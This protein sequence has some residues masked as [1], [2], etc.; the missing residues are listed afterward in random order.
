VTGPEPEAGP[1]VAFGRAVVRVRRGGV[2]VRAD[3]RALVVCAAL[4]A[5]TV[6]VG[7]LGVASGDLELTLAEV[8]HAI[9]DPGAGFTRTVVVEWRIPRV[10]AALLFGA[11]LGVSGA[12]FQALTRN[13]LA[14]PDV[15]G[16]TSGAYT[17][18]LLAIIVFGGAYGTVVAG[19]L[20]GGLLTAALLYLFAYRD[21][22]QGFRLLVVGV[23]VAAMLS[24]ANT[25]LS[26]RADLGVAMSAAAWGVGSLN[27]T[28]WDHV[29][30]GGG[31]I[32]VLLAA[33]VPHA[34]AL[35]Q[36]GLGDDA[37]RASGVAVERTQ[38]VLIVLGVMLVA[39]VTAAAGPIAF[40]AL[41][42]PQ[43]GHRLARTAGVTLLPAAAMGAFLVVVADYTAQHL[44]PTTLP[45]GLVTVV[46]GGSYLVWLLVDRA[47]RR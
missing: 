43:L 47:R 1:P 21:G 29:L 19:A 16:F 32:V 46:L 5:M 36:L 26:L 11:A 39:V 7:L 8:W 28:S 25:Y 24:A 10:L 41:A 30:I 17:G 37:A 40:V 38:R 27:G 4:F 45:V 6:P 42:A 2:A 34:P 13:P 3:V 15:I 14:S 23:A 18:G 44:L 9:T 22:I 31:V 12:I 20:A 33:T 35:A